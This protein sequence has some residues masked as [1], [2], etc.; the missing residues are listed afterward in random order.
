MRDDRRTNSPGTRAGK[1]P[2]RVVAEALIQVGRDGAYSNLVAERRFDA[3]P[4]G[5]ERAFA[6]AL[7]YGVLEREL[8]LRHILRRCS[9]KPPEKLDPEVLTALEMGL[10]QLLYLG[11]VPERAAVNESVA[12]VKKLGKGSA[13]GFVNGVL[14]SF[15]RDGKALHLEELEGVERLAVEASAPAALCRLLADQYGEAA[16]R[17][18]LLA[19]LEPAPV[20]L[21]VNTLRTTPAALAEELAAAGARVEETGVDGCLKLTGGGD[22]TGYAAFAAGKLHVQD[23]SCQ[24]CCAAVGA[25][26]GM[27]VLDACSAPGGKAFTLAEIME[28]TGELVACDLYPA[29]V[30]LIEAGAKRLGLSCIRARVADAAQEDPGLGLFDRVLCDVPCS[31]LGIIRRK[32]E[33]KYRAMEGIGALPEAQYAI[34][35]TAADHVKPGGVLVY[36]TCTVNRDENEAVIGRLLREREDFTPEAITPEGDYFRTL[37]TEDGGDGFFFAAVRRRL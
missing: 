36:S 21:R 3:L 34:L 37:L 23:L 15:L 9:K 7:F 25:E 24:L 28:D 11:S 2:R 12:L 4:A 17:E 22:I 1:D 19:A 26:P 10:Y 27:R 32:P 14:R 5:R 30:G 29:R 31:G 33:L 35:R 6:S 16:A 18:F 8:T 13:A 20:Y